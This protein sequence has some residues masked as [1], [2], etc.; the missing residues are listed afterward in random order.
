MDEPGIWWCDG[1]ERR[2]YIALEVPEFVEACESDSAVTGTDVVALLMPFLS[3]PF[4]K[5]AGRNDGPLGVK[6]FFSR[7]GWLPGFP[8]VR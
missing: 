7:A 1:G 4:M 6:P 2:D 8:I 3:S 5:A